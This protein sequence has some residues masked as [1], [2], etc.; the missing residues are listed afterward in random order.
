M[1]EDNL[2]WDIGWHG[3]QNAYIL[4]RIKT[5]QKKW[6]YP[7]K[8]N[9]EIHILFYTPKMDSLDIKLGKTKFLIVLSHQ[10]SRDRVDK[11]RFS[12][13]KWSLPFR[14]SN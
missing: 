12:S 6:K 8:S 13:I 2:F 7:Q 5:V 11:F 1:M 3:L 10:N 9:T 14:F 4:G